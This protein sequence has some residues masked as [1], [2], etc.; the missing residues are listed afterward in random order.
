M[1]FLVL[2]SDAQLG[3]IS[4]SK[5]EGAIHNGM[6][7]MTLLPW[8]PSIIWDKPAKVSLDTKAV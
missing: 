6:W 3:V 2:A 5:E 1:K 4:G 8:R 7:A